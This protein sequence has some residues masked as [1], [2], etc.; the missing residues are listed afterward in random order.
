MVLCEDPWSKKD[1]TVMTAE[2]G[3]ERS[4]SK[5]DDHLRVHRYDFGMKF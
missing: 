5:E 4:K 2:M 3:G 1:S